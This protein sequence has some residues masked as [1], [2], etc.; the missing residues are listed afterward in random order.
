MS[1]IGTTGIF[2]YFL[3]R[4][5]YPQLFVL[6]AVLFVIDLFAL[7]VVPFVDEILLAGLTLLLGSL[8][9][10][11]ASPDEPERVEKNVTP[12]DEG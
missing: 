8:R 5:R 7:D 2:T 3:S 6:V 4:L 12:S 1:K 10:R 9:A 11:R